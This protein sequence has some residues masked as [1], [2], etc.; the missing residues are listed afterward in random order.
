[1]KNIMLII[2]TSIFTIGIVAISAEYF[3]S[4]IIIAFILLLL[5]FGVA[6]IEYK[7]YKLK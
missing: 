1:M 2:L 7:I 5:I 3:G 6:A 4:V